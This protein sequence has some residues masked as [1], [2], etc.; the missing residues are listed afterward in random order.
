[1]QDRRH[2][3]CGEHFERGALRG[4][5]ERVRVLPDEQRSVDPL[6]AAVFADRLRDREDMRFVERRAQRGST[7]TAGAE[8]HPLCGVVGIGPAIVIRA[9]HLGDIDERIGRDAFSGERGYR[10]ATPR[11]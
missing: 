1:L 11:G 2:A 4:A 6:R 7:M 9:D 8:A 3:V 5:R 10:H